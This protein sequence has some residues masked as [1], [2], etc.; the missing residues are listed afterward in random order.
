MRHLG[1]QKTAVIQ[2]KPARWVFDRRAGCILFNSWVH[3]EPGPAAVQVISPIRRSGPYGHGDDGL[4][5]HDGRSWCAYG[6]GSRAPCC[7]DASWAGKYGT[8]STLLTISSNGF[9]RRVLKTAFTV[10]ING[11]ILSSIDFNDRGAKMHDFDLCSL[12]ERHGFNGTRNMK[13]APDERR[14][15]MIIRPQITQP[16]L[17]VQRCQCLYSA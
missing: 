10:Y 5:E 16:V 7:A 11:K 14:S 12:V 3:M 2:G 6:R 4:P 15:L 1:W 9:P 17:K 13:R 8:W